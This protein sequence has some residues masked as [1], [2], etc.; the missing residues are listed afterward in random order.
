ML[1]LFQQGHL[2]RSRVFFAKRSFS[3]WL[4]LSSSAGALAALQSHTRYH[5]T[6]R[7]PKMWNTLGQCS[8]CT[9]SPSHLSL[10][11]F[12]SINTHGNFVN[13]SRQLFVS[14]HTVRLLN[15][16]GGLTSIRCGERARPRMEPVYMPEYTR[17]RDLERS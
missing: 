15:G 6:P 4:H 10:Q 3:A 7:L 1:L 2:T 11:L 13:S 5:R 9:T 12:L 17:A 16:T 14:R 8:H